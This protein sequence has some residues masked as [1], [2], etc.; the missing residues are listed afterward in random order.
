MSK[1]VK[2]AHSVFGVSGNVSKSAFS[3]SAIFRVF[4]TKK[5]VEKVKKRRFSCFRGY[6]LF[7]KKP[8][9]INPSQKWRFFEF[10][11]WGFFVSQKVKNLKFG[12]KSFSPQYL[13]SSLGFSKFVKKNVNLN[14]KPTLFF[15]SKN[16]VFV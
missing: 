15:W 7:W 14:S 12:R 2:F 1:S 13:F 9:I 16:D 6:P 4:S 11:K 8:L 5:K 3:G 10:Q